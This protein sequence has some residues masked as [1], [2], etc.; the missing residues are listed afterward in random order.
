[1]VTEDWVEAMLGPLV[2][3]RPAVITIIDDVKPEINEE[4]CYSAPKFNKEVVL[5]RDDTAEVQGTAMVMRWV[6]TPHAKGGVMASEQSGTKSQIYNYPN[7]YGQLSSIVAV[8]SG[9]LSS[10]SLITIFLPGLP[11]RLIF[12]TWACVS[13]VVSYV[14]LDNKH[15]SLALPDDHENLFPSCRHLESVQRKRQLVEQPRLPV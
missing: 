5:G 1:M 15:L 12:I 7:L 8:I 3:I 9:S 13:I 14:Q 4:E 11:G 10:V 6:L 2:M